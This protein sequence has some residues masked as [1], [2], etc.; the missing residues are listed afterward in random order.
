[1]RVGVVAIAGAVAAGIVCG[2]ALV[3]EARAQAAEPAFS[4]RQTGAG[5]AAYRAA[6]GRCHGDTLVGRASHEEG[7]EAPTLK[8]PQFQAKWRGKTA[9]DLYDLIRDTMPGDKPGTA[10]PA[11]I[12]GAV[13]A[14]L[15]ANG[16]ADG[17][18]GP[19]VTAED[20]IRIQLK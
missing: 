6:C 4:A 17:G 18:E 2:A 8:G 20:L 16:R 19:D 14:I 3:R 9:K 15:Q 5:G 1:M 12:L 10:P 13:A 11:T 7:I